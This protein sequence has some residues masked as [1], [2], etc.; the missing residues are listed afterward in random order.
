MSR[1]YTAVPLGFGM[2]VLP[3]TMGVVKGSLTFLSR[4]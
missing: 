2:D 1:S 4:K 3:L